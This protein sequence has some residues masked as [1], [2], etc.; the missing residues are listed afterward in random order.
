MFM[1]GICGIKTPTP[2]LQQET[3]FEAKINIP[4]TRQK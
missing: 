1:L 4:A 2:S 3:T